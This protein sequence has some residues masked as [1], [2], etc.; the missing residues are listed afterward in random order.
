MIKK[1]YSFTKTFI[2]NL[3]NILLRLIINFLFLIIIKIKDLLC[4]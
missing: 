2:K 3:I 1:I 4:N